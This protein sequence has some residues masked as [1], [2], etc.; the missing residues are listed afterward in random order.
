MIFT[1]SEK[2][3]IAIVDLAEGKHEYKFFV[4]GEWKVNTSD[5]AC[6]N[7]LGTDNNII[8]IKDSDFEELENALLKDP[9]DKSENPYGGSGPNQIK[10]DGNII[11]LSCFISLMT[12][13]LS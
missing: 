2:D 7:D 13:L 12:Y 11:F 8:T 9:N 1:F 3:F 6:A 4:D 5:I 10:S